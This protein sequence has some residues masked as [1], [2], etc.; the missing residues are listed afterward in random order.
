MTTAR[1]R[2]FVLTTRD[3]FGAA[4]LPAALARAGFEVGCAGF[5]SALVF[6]ASP[7]SARYLLPSQ[8]E[9]AAFLAATGQALADFQP[10]LVVPGDDPAVEV[11]HALYAA[12]SGPEQAGLRS[13]LQ[14]SLGDPAHFA[15]TQS[16]AG[17][18]AVARELGVR[19]PEQVAVSGVEQALGFARRVG[20]PIVLKMENSCAGFG[21]SICETEA[22]IEAAFVYFEGRSSA[23]KMPLSAVTAQR[24]VKGNVAMR[25]VSTAA[26]KVL[27]GLSAAKRETHP[28][29][30]GPSTVVEF[31]DHPEMDSATQAVTRALGLSGFA[32]FDFMIE[33]QTQAAYLIELNPR[34]TPI[35][36]L[37]GAFGSDLCGALYQELTGQPP[38][39]TLP[40][41]TNRLVA[42]FPQEWIRDPSSSH[43][44]VAHHDVPWDDPGLVQALCDNALVQFGWAHLRREEGRRPGLRALAE[45]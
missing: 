13:L 16:R 29:P 44:D 6:A 12:A 27:A 1:A 2:I 19:F 34:P 45:R 35:C 38:A 31:I 26:G 25:A 30:T 9:D 32:S 42:L 37:G 11:L 5:A 23:W 21:T 7:A 40:A 14:R 8:A 36:H 33:E 15:E 41:K 3:W 24:F 20:V 22:A 4:R 43:F 10:A 28:A 18:H 17:L 39:A